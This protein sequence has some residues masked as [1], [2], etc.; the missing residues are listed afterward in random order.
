MLI[1]INEEQNRRVEEFLDEGILNLKRCL[2]N[3]KKKFG[4]KK[5]KHTNT[6]F[7]HKKINKSIINNTDINN[8]MNSLKNDYI[9][10]YGQSTELINKTIN[11]LNTGLH[12]MPK[13]KTNENNPNI[14]KSKYKD[15][16]IDS[17]VKKAGKPLKILKKRIPKN[18]FGKKINLKKKLINF[19][20]HY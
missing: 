1:D 3:E 13:R 4:K 14:K 6:S 18:T 2:I 19:Y 9:T 17:V 16:M 5:E 20:T 15:G 8:E 11:A 10:Y 7:Q 12:Y